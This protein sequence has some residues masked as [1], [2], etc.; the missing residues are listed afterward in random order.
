[1]KQM[2][3]V[4]ELFFQGNEADLQLGRSIHPF[5]VVR[6]I[7]EG[8]DEE[9]ENTLKFIAEVA[10]VPVKE[11]VKDLLS[12]RPY[13]LKEQQAGNDLLESWKKAAHVFKDRLTAL[14]GALYAV[15][16]TYR[17]TGALESWLQV[18]KPQN[19]KNCMTDEQHS[20]NAHPD[21]WPLT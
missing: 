19:S 14:P 20:K 17:G 15:I 16:A 8:K 13:M 10:D 21:Q 1:M 12:T 2:Q 9:L 7:K 3:V 6:W 4:A 5:D 11:L 18:G